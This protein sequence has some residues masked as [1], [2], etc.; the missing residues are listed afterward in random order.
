MISEAERAAGTAS[1]STAM[2][3]LPVARSPET[4]QVSI[5][6]TSAAGIS[7]RRMSGRPLSSSRGASPS[8]R[9]HPPISQS[10]LSTLLQKRQ[11]PPTTSS[12]PAPTAR[13][14]GAKTPPTTPDGSP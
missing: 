14:I 11:R 2:S 1:P 3:W 5:T 6:S 9:T 10:Q 8:M 4:D 13:P 7:T 12:S